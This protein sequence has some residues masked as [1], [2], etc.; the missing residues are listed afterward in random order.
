VATDAVWAGP[1]G[2]P[3][4]HA[5][6]AALHVAALLDRRGSLVADARESYWRRATGGQFAPPDLELGERLLVDCRLVE[7]RERMLYPVPELER[8]LDGAFDDAVAA[9]CARAAERVEPSAFDSPHELERDL[10]ELIPDPER[11]EELLRALARRFDDAHRRLLGAIG[12]EVVVAALRTELVSLGYPELA[13]GVRHVSLETDQAGYD[14][15]A[16]RIVGSRRLIEV[17]A[18]TSLASE[19]DVHI[20]RNEADTGLRYRDWSLVLCRVTDTDRREAEIVGWCAASQLAPAL[21]ADRDRGRWENALI[22]VSIDDLTPGLPS[23][24]A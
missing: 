19:V 18:V 20:S 5:V 10:G 16:A 4:A 22:T 11:R 23:A 1:A 14:I 3:T 6:K 7:E 17:K 12:E 15:S 2:L 8:L 13:R 24:A 9:I 21:P